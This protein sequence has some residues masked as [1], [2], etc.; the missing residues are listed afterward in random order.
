M[1]EAEIKVEARLAALERFACHTHN[2][3]LGI[4][5]RLSNMTDAEM[6]AIESA[7]LEAL[8][9]VP[10]KGMPPALSDVLSDEIFVEL[11]RLLEYARDLRSTDPE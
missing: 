5:R 1:T 9:L 4:L 6:S 11:S 3:A 2:M 10:V 8:R 7:S